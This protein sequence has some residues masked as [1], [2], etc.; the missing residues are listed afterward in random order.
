MDTLI[1]DIRYGARSLLKRG[2]STS[3]A[4]LALALGIGVNTAIFSV[5]NNVLLRPMPFAEPER[6]VSVWE[7]GIRVGLERN[8]LAPANFIDVRSQNKV[9]SDLGAFGEK[10]LNLS[11]SGDPERLDGLLVSANVLSLLGVQPAIG[12]VFIPEEDQPGQNQV[13]VL[14]YRLWERRFNRDPRIVG[15]KITLDSQPFTVVG[16]MP[17]GFFFPARDTE[18][19][20]PLAM[21]PDEAAGRGDHYL[22]GVAR[23]KAGVT[24][25]QANSDLQALGKRLEAEYPRTNDGLTFFASSFHDDYVGNIRTPLLIMFAAVV[26][27]LLIAQSGA[28][29]H[30]VGHSSSVFR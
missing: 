29:G 19:W 1:K 7:R 2:A 18:L 8:E 16:V 25:A 10:S 4:V 9:F 5:V 26:A 24:I 28:R 23:L 22:L 20:T 30:A 11:G 15:Q 6:V 27:V 12:R 17:D 21:G 3:L 13:V 14:S